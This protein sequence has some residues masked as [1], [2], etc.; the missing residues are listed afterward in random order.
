[1]RFLRRSWLVLCCASLIIAAGGGSARAAFPGENGR[2]AFA[3]A[4]A[5]EGLPRIWTAGK[6]GNTVHRLMARNGTNPAWSADGSKIVFEHTLTGAQSGASQLIVS[7]DDGDKSH[8][9]LTGQGI[10]N[11]AWA[12]NGTRLVFES[13]N[14][15]AAVGSHGE[16]VHAVATPKGAGEFLA[17]EWSPDGSRIAFQ[18]C[19]AGSCEIW[20]V[21]PDGR[22]LRRVTN[23]PMDS[24]PD[25]S[26]D[27]RRLVFARSSS[28]TESD[29]FV[30][31]RN[32]SREVQ[33][34][35]TP[36]TES[37]P[38]FSPNGRQVIFSR[39]CFGNSMTAELFTMAVRGTQLTT[40]RQITSNDAED[41]LPSWGSFPHGL[42]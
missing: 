23:G 19:H 2:I 7:D 11:A 25:W 33:L 3:R 13:A 39:C 21:D 10:G 31:G 1:M 18:R 29:L 5:H 14:G 6:H 42:T 28:S 30:I 9:A 15:I 35:S 40:D 41:T 32:G 22:D 26:P 8:V 38:A 20:T 24:A 4:R 34:T 12:P 36:E 37:D 27:G 16:E 17:P